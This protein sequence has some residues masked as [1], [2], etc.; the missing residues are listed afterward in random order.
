MT[1]EGKYRLI[2]CTSNI[3]HKDWYKRLPK[4]NDGSVISIHHFDVIDNLIDFIKQYIPYND[5]EIDRIL[6]YNKT[7]IDGDL[8]NNSWYIIKKGEDQ[9]TEYT[10][11]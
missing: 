5:K 2:L 8:A 7:K 11:F 1:K 3:S 6:E 10:S 9:M 4:R